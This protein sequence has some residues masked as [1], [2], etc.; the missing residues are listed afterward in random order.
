METEP[1]TKPTRI[2]ATELA[3]SLSDILSR[4]RYRGERF[5]VE[6][7]GET[8]AVIEPPEPRRRA[9]VG[10][11]SARI[12]SLYMPGDGF[13]DDVEAAHAAQGLPNLPEWPS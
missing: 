11:L 3:R 7:N 2:T 12:G 9:T 10:E 5:I 6:R 4:V 8:V 13:A 1:R